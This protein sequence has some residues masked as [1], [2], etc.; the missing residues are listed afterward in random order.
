L[1]TY[2]FKA[3]DRLTNIPVLVLA[4]AQDRA[5]AG[6]PMQELARRLPRARLVVL[7]QGGHFPYLE[8]P[9]RFT[10]ELLSFLTGGTQ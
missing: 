5:V 7:E 10:R 2:Q 8:E 6:P 1:L 9:E 3:W 4:G